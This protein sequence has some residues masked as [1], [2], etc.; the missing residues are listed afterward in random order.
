VQRHTH[1]LL[2]GHEGVSSREAESAPSFPGVRLFSEA[3]KE[4][5]RA[6]SYRRAVKR[7]ITLDTKVVVSKDHVSCDL[8]DEVAILNLKNG[9]Y[10]G[11]NP[12]GAHIWNLIQTPTTAS[13][14]C[15]TITQ[16][17][18]VEPER[19]ERD[20]LTLLGKLECEGLIQV[21]KDETAA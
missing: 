3:P 6:E 13:V 2:T 7:M 12:L 8:A 1:A 9:V 16:Q 19:C 11:L 10:Y 20:L 21:V 5:L 14:L 4:G 15:K 17:F 18:E